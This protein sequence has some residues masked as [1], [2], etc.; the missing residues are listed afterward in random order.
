M[1]DALTYVIVAVLSMAVF[2]AYGDRATVG[3][4]EQAAGTLVLLLLYGA[5]LIPLAYCYSFAF[6]SASTAQ[7]PLPPS[8]STCKSLH[9]VLCSGM[10]D[11]VLKNMLRGAFANFPLWR[12]ICGFFSLSPNG[13]LPERCSV[14]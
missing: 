14:T 6:N 4:G 5:A 8:P 7:A 9:C 1:W 2:A 12:A 11:R 13:E 3:S 10:P